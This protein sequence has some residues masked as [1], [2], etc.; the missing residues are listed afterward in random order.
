MSVVY[1]LD[2][3]ICSS[4]MRERPIVVLERLQETVEAQHRIVISVVTYYEML[5]GA[6]GRKAS[7]RHAHLV[8]AFVARL[9]DILPWDRDAAEQSARISQTLAAKP[10][11]PRERP[12][13]AMTQ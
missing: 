8:K 9:S 6:T 12:S 3:N 1:M 13:A 2:T 11:P 7:P 5:L 10:L 4:I